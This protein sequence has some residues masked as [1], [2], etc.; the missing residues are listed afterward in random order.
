VQATVQPE[1]DR[2]RENIDALAVL[3]RL[4]EQL[5]RTNAA[6]WGI[7][8]A[9]WQAAARRVADAP[10]PHQSDAAP[11][12]H[13]IRAAQSAGRRLSNSGEARFG[14]ARVGRDP[15]SSHAGKRFNR[16]LDAAQRRLAELRELVPAEPGAATKRP[17][18]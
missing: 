14:S 16:D 11:V 5:R 13:A 3:L 8:E 12:S 2:L 17:R 1:G 7:T 6:K 4:A 15:D 9:E 10:V 18:E